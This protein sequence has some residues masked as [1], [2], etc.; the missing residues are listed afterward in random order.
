VNALDLVLLGRRLMKIGEEAMRGSNAPALPTGVRLVLIDVFAHPD[1]SIKQI[2]ART[3]LRQSHVSVAVAGLREQGVLQ[4]SADPDD[5]R[6]TLVRVRAEH[7]R[8]VAIAGSVSVDGALSAAFDEQDPDA[9]ATIV[10][11]LDAL[12]KRLQPIKPAPIAR[13]LEAARQPSIA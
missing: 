13:E 10:A 11:E 2:T 7:P 12:A 8:R 5:G 6:R 1:S 3:G 4:T 9:L